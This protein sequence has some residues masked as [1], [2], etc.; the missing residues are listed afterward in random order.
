M[1]WKKMSKSVK[2]GHDVGEPV[3]IKRI[4]PSQKFGEPRNWKQRLWN[5]MIDA[6]LFPEFQQIDAVEAEIII[7]AEKNV[8]KQ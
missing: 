6:G 5:R 7:R 2:F 4:R 8:M 1:K 3:F